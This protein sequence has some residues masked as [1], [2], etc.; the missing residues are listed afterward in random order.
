[1]S[2]FKRLSPRTWTYLGPACVAIR[3]RQLFTFLSQRKDQVYVIRHEVGPPDGS[4]RSK[5]MRTEISFVSSCKTGSATPKAE[6]ATTI[7]MENK[8][9]LE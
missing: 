8:V 3:F 5:Q 9:R 1:M 2:Q 7:G 4:G 6:C